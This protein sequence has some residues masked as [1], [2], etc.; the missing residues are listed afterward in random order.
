MEAFNLQHLLL[1]LFLGVPIVPVWAQESPSPSEFTSPSPA[2]KVDQLLQGLNT[3][4]DQ[5]TKTIPSQ[6]EIQTTTKEELNK[7]HA[8]EYK[9]VDYELT[10]P[11]AELEKNLN[12][13]GAERWECLGSVIQ[14]IRMRFVCRRHPASYLRY[15]P[16]IFP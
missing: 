9:V 2:S 15:I 1:F 7:I 4:I 10:L 5:I 13:L 16:R 14:G 12:T 11:A 6:E 3:K 8:F